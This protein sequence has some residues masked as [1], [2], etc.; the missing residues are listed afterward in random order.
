[1]RPWSNLQVLQVKVA[2]KP[3]DVRMSGVTEYDMITHTTHPSFRGNTFNITIDVQIRLLTKRW[4]WFM[5]L[6]PEITM[7]LGAGGSFAEQKNHMIIPGTQMTIVLVGKGH[8]L[9]VY[10]QKLRSFGF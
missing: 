4:T 3:G 1:M 10:L 6:T 9:E 5:V 7:A 8:V 2:V